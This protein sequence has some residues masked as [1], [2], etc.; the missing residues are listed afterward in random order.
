MRIRIYS[1]QYFDQESGLHYNNHRYYDPK[2]GR[3][4]TPDP[5][6]LTG[7]TNLYTYAN[8]NPINAVDPLGLLTSSYYN[9]HG[10]SNYD[11]DYGGAWTSPPPYYNP[12]HDMT[13]KISNQ[14]LEDTVLAAS[15]AAALSG[16]IKSR[17]GTVVFTGI[18]TGAS[19]ILAG[20]KSPNQSIVD[21]TSETLKMMQKTRPEAS[22]LSGKIIDKLVRAEWDANT[23]VWL[24]LNGVDDLGDTFLDYLESFDYQPPQPSDKEL[25]WQSDKRCE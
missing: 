23:V 19:A 6:G 1:G 11:I 15:T 21:V 9:A 24:I 14:T 20:R 25:Y 17:T 8:L 10:Y 12:S 5:I 4:L 16:S 3:Y 2:T 7:G 22:L 13:K 18:A